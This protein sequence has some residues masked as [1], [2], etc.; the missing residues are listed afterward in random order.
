MAPKKFYLIFV[1]SKF[2]FV[3]FE[4]LTA[5][6]VTFWMWFH[7]ILHL[8]TNVLEEYAALECKGV[9]EDADSML[10]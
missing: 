10:L 9:S 8:D 1:Q 5:V 7:V 4:A 2:S 6:S 3:R